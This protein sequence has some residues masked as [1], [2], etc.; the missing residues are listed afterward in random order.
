MASA[1]DLSCVLKFV[2]KFVKIFV[3]KFF[4]WLCPGLVTRGEGVTR[5]L[6][7]VQFWGFPYA[8]STHP[9]MLNETKFDMVTH[10]GTKLVLRRQPRSAAHSG[11]Y[12]NVLY[13][14]TFTYLLTPPQ[15][16]GAPALPNFGGSLPFMSTDSTPFNT[17]HVWQDNMDHCG[18]GCFL[19]QL[20]LPSRGD[21]AQGSQFWV[22]LY[23]CLHPST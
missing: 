17:D 1:Y 14:F 3:L 9:L 11:F 10:M 19:G 20:R 16:C 7:T 13:K 8:I 2:L 18:V 6:T 12:E 23:L 22:P 4:F 15:G 21:K 5:G